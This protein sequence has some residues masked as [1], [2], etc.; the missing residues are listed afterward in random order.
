M[1]AAAVCCGSDTARCVSD[2]CANMSVAS[3]IPCH[4]ERHMADDLPRHIRQTSGEESPSGHGLTGWLHLC[5]WLLGDIVLST[6]ADGPPPPELCSAHF[7]TNSTL[8]HKT[9]SDT[10]CVRVFC[11]TWCHK[12]YLLTTYWL[13][14]IENFLLINSD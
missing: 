2:V 7:L 1:T 4:D 10:W 13:S 9:Y 12:K 11:V 5:Q 6:P 14:L 8:T 3:W